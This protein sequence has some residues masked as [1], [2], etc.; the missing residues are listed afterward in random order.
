MLLRSSVLNFD[1]LCCSSRVLFDTFLKC[2]KICLLISTAFDLSAW[3]ELFWAIR[4][5]IWGKWREIFR[6]STV[7]ILNLSL[8]FFLEP[9][10][11]STPNPIH[12]HKWLLP[13]QHSALENGWPQWFSMPLPRPL[14]AWDISTWDKSPWTFLWLLT[15]S[16]ICFFPIGAYSW[17]SSK[18][19]VLGT[20]LCFFYQIL[21]PFL[22]S[23][24]IRFH[25]ILFLLSLF[26]C[27]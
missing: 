22:G 15:H 2:Y 12:P 11:C 14:M 7:L 27:S 21:Y 10:H 23:Y 16:L 5:Q 17:N 4:I 24:Y 1:L 13:T 20:T 3:W 8:F 19:S 25:F 18:R 6:L 9:C 26:D